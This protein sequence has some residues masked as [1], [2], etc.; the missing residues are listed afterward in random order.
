MKF[1]R[2]EYWSGQPFPSPGGLPDPGIEPGSPAVQADSLP[3]EPGRAA[4]GTAGSSVLRSTGPGTS[5]SQ[6]DGPRACSTEG[7]LGTEAIGPG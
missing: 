6:A 5:P 7:K 1:S 3:S 4:E 2:Q